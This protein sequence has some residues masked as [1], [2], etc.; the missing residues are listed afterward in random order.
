MSLDIPAFLLF[1]FLLPT[2][3][4]GVTYHSVAHSALKYAKKYNGGFYLKIFHNWAKLVETPRQNT[5]FPT[6]MARNDML[7]YAHKCLY[8][9]FLINNN[10]IYRGIE[11][12]CPNEQNTLRGQYS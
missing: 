8:I 2:L 12:N 3:Y 5:C 10:T 9:V 7:H 4:P 1:T 11:T 6:C